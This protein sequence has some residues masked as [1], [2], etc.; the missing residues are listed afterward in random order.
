MYNKLTMSVQPE[1]RSSRRG[2]N[3]TAPLGN[4]VSTVG[5]QLPSA[6]PIGDKRVTQSHTR[7]YLKFVNRF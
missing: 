5:C 2:R 3:V 7:G 4:D 1:G 6:Q